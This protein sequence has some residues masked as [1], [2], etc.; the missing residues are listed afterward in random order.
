MALRLVLIRLLHVNNCGGCGGA[1]IGTGVSGNVTLN[2]RHGTAQAVKPLLL[3]EDV[4][5][6]KRV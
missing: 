6:L 3:V 1:A 4:V 2:D 5:D